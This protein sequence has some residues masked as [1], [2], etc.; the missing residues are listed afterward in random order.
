MKS[1]KDRVAV[2]TGAGSGL[3]RALAVRLAKEGCH[4][5]L[6]DVVAERLPEVAAEVERLGRRSS[7]HAFDVADR[8]AWP[9]FVDD[10]TAAHGGVH[11]LVNNAGVSLSGLFRTASLDDLE[12]QLGVNLYGVLYGCHAFLPQLLENDASHIVNVSSIFGIVSVP[13]NSAYC[14]AKHAVRSLSESLWLELA[15]TPVGVTWVHPGA[16]A[17]RI[18][19]DGRRNQGHLKRDTSRRLIEAGWPPDRAAR[20]IMQGVRRGRRRI[21]LG[22]GASRLALLQQ[23]FPVTYLDTVLRT[24]RR[25]I[26]VQ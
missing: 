7:T 23:W 19:E 24:W 4:V 10:V 1:F 5:A 17:T 9:G 21:V 6:T 11:L 12:W 18:V 3:G 14:M 13:E 16:I 15:D 22:P 2:V 25:R 26:A 8:E 20:V